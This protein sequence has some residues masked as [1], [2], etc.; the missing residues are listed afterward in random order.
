[1]PGKALRDA[2]AYHAMVYDP[3]AHPGGVVCP[4]FGA[5]DQ[6]DQT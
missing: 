5:H 6:D 3:N 4:E 2:T 1:M